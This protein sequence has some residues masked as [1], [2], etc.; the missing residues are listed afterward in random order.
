MERFRGNEDSE[1]RRR[2]R[3]VDNADPLLW[4]MA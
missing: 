2:T 1:Q 3:L 4:E